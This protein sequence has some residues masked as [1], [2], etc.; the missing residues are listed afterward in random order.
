MLSIL[1]NIGRERKQLSNT[2]IIFAGV[3][4]TLLFASYGFISILKSESGSGE[5]NETK[6]KG[7][8]IPLIMSITIISATITGT[9]GYIALVGQIENMNYEISAQQ[10]IIVDQSELIKDLK[11]KNLDMELVMNEG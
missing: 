9:A 1:F 6:K 8:K 3:V 7:L 4:I 11:D 5:S 10:K 2:F